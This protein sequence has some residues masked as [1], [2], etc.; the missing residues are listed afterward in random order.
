MKK[1]L[2]IILDGW[3]ITEDP[4]VSAIAKADTRYIDYLWENYPHTTLLASGEAVGL[5]DGQMGNSEVGHTCIGAGR[6]IYQDLLRL[7]IAVRNKEFEKNAVFQE[8]VEYTKTN[9]KTLHLLGLVSDGGVHSHIEHAKDLIR[10][11]SELGAYKIALHAFTDGRDCDPQSGL[12]FIEQMLEYIAQYPNTVLA[13]VVGRYYAMDR[14]KRW[15]RIQLAYNAITK[16]IGKKTQNLFKAIKESYENGITDEFIQPIIH[17]D[18]HQQPLATIEPNDAVLFFNFRSDRGRELTEALSQRDF[19]NYNMQ[20]LPLKYVTLTEYDPTFENVKVMFE[21][22]D[23]SMTLG[24]VIAKHGKTQLRIAET[25]KYP[26]VTFF[27]NG[28]QELPFENEHRELVPSPKVATYDLLPQM[29][30]YGV[31]NVALH[32]IA[33]KQPDFVCVNF[34]NPDMVGHTGD[35]QAVIQACTTVSH[36]VEQIT[37]LAIKYNY[38]VLIIADHGNADYMIN[39]DGSPNTAHSLAPVPCIYVDESNKNVKL[40][41]GGTLQD[42]A[43]T[44]LDIMSIPKPVQ[45]TGNSLILRE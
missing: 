24:E 19:E 43:P 4:K 12:G 30:A 15:E 9:K 11:A 18:K 1:A 7:N 10:A 2:L 41:A 35:M 28:G 25:E 6:V 39:P 27:L 29:S 31:T 22:Q 20:K 13:T 36:C 34:A 23:I 42:V 44:I 45:M 33:I 21:K 3:G 16:G 32:Q 14:D 37:N 17:V 8:L 5:P 40:R 38:A 26:H